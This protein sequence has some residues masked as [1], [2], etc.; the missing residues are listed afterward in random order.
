MDPCGVAENNSETPL[1]AALKPPPNLDIV[2]LLSEYME[3]PGSQSLAYLK[4]MIEAEKKISLVEFKK[5]L[6]SHPLDKVKSESKSKLNSTFSLVIPYSF[7]A[8]F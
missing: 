3:F 8:R 4:L 7:L 2:N 1:E 6:T 5:Q